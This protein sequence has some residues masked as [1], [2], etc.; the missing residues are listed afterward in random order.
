MRNLLDFNKAI[1]FLLFLGVFILIK[2]AIAPQN[3]VES[4]AEIVLNK[5]IDGSEKISLIA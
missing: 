5:L 4:E 1:I 2:L 3:Q